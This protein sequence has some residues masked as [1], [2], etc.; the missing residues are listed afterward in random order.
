MKRLIGSKKS[1]HFV[2]NKKLVNIQKSALIFHAISDHNEQKFCAFDEKQSSLM[3]D[4]LESRKKELFASYRSKYGRV[5]SGSQWEETIEQVAVSSLALDIYS[6]SLS[7][8]LKIDAVTDISCMSSRKSLFILYNYARICTLLDH[9]QEKVGEGV[10]EALPD[11]NNVF[12]P[13]LTE[14]AEWKLI[15]QYVL[16]YPNLMHH[17]HF[18]FFDD[19]SASLLNLPVNQLCRFL[20]DLCHDF[21]SYYHQ[22]KVLLDPQPHLSQLIAARLYLVTIIK[23]IMD[24]CFMLL[25]IVPPKQM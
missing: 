23:E 10:Y 20:C 16:V 11:I 1:M 24:H 4:F 12:F 18:S 7:N 8:H 15:L 13:L 6:L 25:G 21:S 2:S 17:L 9:Y 5:V 22:T 19:S 3:D 14:E